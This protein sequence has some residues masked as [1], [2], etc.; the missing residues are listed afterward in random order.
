[1]TFR[2]AILFSSLLISVAHA[3]G[4]AHASDLKEVPQHSP[5]ERISVVRELAD[6]LQIAEADASAAFDL[7]LKSIVE[8]DD[9]WHMSFIHNQSLTSASLDQSAQRF[10]IVSV[11]TNGRF[12]SFTYIKF[13]ELGQIFYYGSESLPRDSKH[14]TEALGKLK[15]NP[16]FAVEKETDHFAA[17]PTS[18]R[19]Q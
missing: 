8:S 5:N 15:S 2:A 14:A 13:A 18:P 11:V 7:T 10:V 19:F 16:G 1:M 4:V 3:F 9:E 17:V 12:S 6:R